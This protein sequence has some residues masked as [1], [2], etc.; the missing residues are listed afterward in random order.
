MPFAHLDAPGITRALS[1]IADRPADLA[2]LF[3]ERREEIEL[4]PADNAPGLCVWRES[5]IA[6]R[7]LRDN[8]SW[9]TG[10]D[11]IDRQIFRDALR[12]TARAMPRASYPEPDLAEEPWREA[13]SAPEIL[14]LPAAVAR[15]L[16]AHRI[17]APLRLRVRRHRRWVRVIGTQLASG[18]ERESFYS[19]QAMLPEARYG[20]LTT[21]LGSAAEQ[22]ARSLVRSLRGR[23]AAP[24]ERATGVCVLGPAATAVLLH[25]AVAHALEAD[26]L[27]LLGHPEAAL[28]S[29][30][31]SNL[32]NVFDDPS[33]APPGVRR[34]ADDEGF[35]VARRCLLRAGRV[36]QPLCDT[37]W[38]RRSEIFTAGAGRRGNRHLPPGPRSTHLELA[39]GELSSQELLSDAEEG[40]YLPEAERGHLDPLS[41]QFTLHFPWGLRIQNQVP[42]PTVGPFS[43][44]API[45]ELLH[46]VTGIGLEVRVAE[47]GWCAKD[48]IK[49]PVWA[50]VPEIRL[51]G[52]E[53][54]P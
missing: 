52:V 50:T 43:L 8:R 37:A 13:P 6:V 42:G 51:E 2:D 17:E 11:G 32:L 25:E 40:L 19:L 44:R 41:G 23:E 49:L 4:P 10:R 30:M 38:A 39:P 35:P 34:T 28:G 26:T 5:G 21:D 36:E 22:V 9:L 24:P 18:V 3:L 15:A 27:A 48:G 31:G 46:R 45:R 29:E 54:R 12:R 33:T 20:C 7:L 16:R 47:A 53:I 1:Q 14:E